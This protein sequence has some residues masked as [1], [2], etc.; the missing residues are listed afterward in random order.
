[1]IM[2]VYGIA[3]CDT[4]KKALNWLREN[5]I[6][7]EFH[8]YKKKG[9]TDEKIRQWSVQLGWE[10]LVNKRGTT[11]RNLPAE[12][13]QRLVDEKTAIE[14]MIEKPSVIKRPVIEGDKILVGFDEAEYKTIFKK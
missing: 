2:K 13:Q 7:F 4:V 14:L 1:M 6:D 3:N 11:W 5:K 9:I 8:D 10:K 12:Q